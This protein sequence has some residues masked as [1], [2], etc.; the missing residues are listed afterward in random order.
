MIEVVLPDMPG[1]DFYMVLALRAL[2]KQRRKMRHLII[3]AKTQE[4]AVSH[5]RI[6]L[7]DCPAHRTDAK[8]VLEKWQ[9]DED[10]RIDAG[11]ATVRIQ[12]LSVS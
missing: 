6:D 12:I 5:V 8:G 3:E 2:S 7:F 4:P 9:L 10:N 11:T 1:D